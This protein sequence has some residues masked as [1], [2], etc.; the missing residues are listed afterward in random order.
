MLRTNQADRV[1][2]ANSTTT[3]NNVLQAHGGMTIATNEDNNT[4]ELT[5]KRFSATSPSGSDDI[6][7]IRVADGGL[8][9]IINNDADLDSG[10]YQFQKM[11]GGLTVPA[12]INCDTI[13]TNGIIRKNGDT[14]TYLEF[15]AANSF[16]VVTGGTEQLS[17]SG[18]GLTIQDNIVHLSLIHI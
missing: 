10:T 16:R 12:A 8:N 14:D 3:V 2:I 9:F 6:V 17:I 7:D 18:S 1:I 11:A 15:H 13:T 4:P 5:L